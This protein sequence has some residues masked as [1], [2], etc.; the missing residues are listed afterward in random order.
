MYEATYTQPIKLP[1][2]TR[3]YSN[4]REVCVE[5]VFML[6][7]IVCGELDL[8]CDHPEREEE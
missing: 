6:Q 1:H 8:N 5:G 3:R 4:T 2:Q 7:C